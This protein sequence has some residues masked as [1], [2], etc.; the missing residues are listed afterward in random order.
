MSH[1]SVAVFSYTP[2]DVE[3]LLAPYC[4][5]PENPEYLEFKVASEPMDEIRSTF[6]REKGPSETLKDFVSRWYG[7]TYN[8]KLGVCGYLCN[9]NAKWDWWE[10]GGRWSNKLNLKPGCKGNRGSHSW[11]NSTELPRDG[12]CDQA[13][14][15]NVDF[16]MDLKAYNKAIR[17]WEVVVEGDDIRENENPAQF[18]TFYRR[19]YYLKQ[20][21]DKERYA[22]SY[23]S[24]T[25]WALVTPNGEWYENGEM[26]WFGMP[27]ATDESRAEYESVLQRTLSEADPNLWVSIIDCHI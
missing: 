23:A 18:N 25:T 6:E 2:D 12:Y 15:K 13:Q 10:L 3:D 19:E 20:F 24:F 5:S 26:G 27:N 11:T 8:E 14:I 7:Y 1:F 4:E 9:P 21:R 22:R 16:S 17:F